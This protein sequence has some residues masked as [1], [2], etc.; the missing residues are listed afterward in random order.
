MRSRCSFVQCNP[1]SC[2][3]CMIRFVS[4]E[5]KEG[6]DSGTAQSVVRENAK[7]VFAN[8]NAIPD[9]SKKVSDV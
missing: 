9:L 2:S 7:R 4:C 5:R 1:R 6:V 3:Y 8:S